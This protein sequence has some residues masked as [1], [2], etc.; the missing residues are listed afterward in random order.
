[1]PAASAR[2]LAWLDFGRLAV[3]RRGLR[4]RRAQT[5]GIASLTPRQRQI[6]ELAAAGATNR[7]IAQQLFLS[8]K[9]VETHLGAVYEKLGVDSRARL[10]A[11][12]TSPS[13]ES[14]A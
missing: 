13:H 12:L 10:T 3:D 2:C 4:P 5:T 1:V 14:P 11:A 9:T 7:G 6:C 8:V